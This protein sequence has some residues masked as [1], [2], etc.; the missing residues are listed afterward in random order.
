MTTERHGRTFES[1]LNIGRR[2]RETDGPEP[3]LDGAHPF[4]KEAA[5]QVHPTG[6]I[7]AAHVVPVIA[8]RTFR[9]AGFQHH[10]MEDQSRTL[11]AQ[12]YAVLLGERKETRHEGAPQS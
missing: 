3:A 12:R 4:F 8:D 6:C 9:R 5:A 1:F 2:V 7:V 11:R 10:R